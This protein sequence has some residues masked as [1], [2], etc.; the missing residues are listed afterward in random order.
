[1]Y[2]IFNQNEFWK[3]FGKI[4]INQNTKAKIPMDVVLDN[5][6]LTKGVKEVLLKWERDY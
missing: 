6:C 4:G 2:I 3:S 5:G 1:M